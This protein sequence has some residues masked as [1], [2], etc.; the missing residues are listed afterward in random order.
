MQNSNHKNN[1]ISAKPRI[2]FMIITAIFIALT[3]VFTAF[4]NIQLPAMSSGGL[5]HL[6]NIPLFIGA[7]IFGKKVGALAGGIGMALFDLFSPWAVWT[8]YTL[9]IVGLMGYFV[10]LITEKHNTVRFYILAIFVA[11]LIKIVGYYFAEVILFGN[12]VTPLLS[13]VANIMQVAVAG[14][15]VIP[16]VGRLKTTVLKSLKINF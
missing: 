15:I 1:R 11:M 7:I 3:Y 4:V 12:W 10:G 13:I 2:Y 16:I 8:L 14:I 5:I 6:G 9:I